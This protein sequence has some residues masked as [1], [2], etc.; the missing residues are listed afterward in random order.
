[1]DV[2][3]EHLSGLSPTT[4]FPSHDTTTL[5]PSE[6]RKSF[7]LMLLPLELRRKIYLCMLPPQTH[8]VTTHFPST[9]YF[10]NT[11]NV[12]ATSQSTYPFGQLPEKHHRTYTVSQASKIDPNLKL[13][14][15]ILRVCKTIHAEAEE[16]LYGAKGVIFDFGIHVNV[17]SSFLIDRSD[18]AR[19]HI[20]EARLARE[21][22]R[23]S[24]PHTP[25]NEL[26]YSVCADLRSSLKNL[27]NLSLILWSDT[28]SSNEFPGGNAEMRSTQTSS[29]D[30]REWYYTRT[31]LDIPNLR[32]VSITVWGFPHAGMETLSWSPGGREGFDGWL[33]RKMVDDSVL[34]KRMI[35]E[36]VVEEREVLVSGSACY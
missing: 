34:K 33:A 10:Y 12:P 24:I 16:I 2:D 18:V 6:A 29:Q 11:S 8:R 35:G 15:E 36:G 21:M 1:M 23:S 3:L 4:H 13:Y 19:H 25:Q 17:I 14:P 20:K 28:G 26:W 22:P 31:I 7:P 32:T 5:L 30:W 9:G 27:K